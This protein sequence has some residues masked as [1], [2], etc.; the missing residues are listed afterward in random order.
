VGAGLSGLLGL[1]LTVIALGSNWP[2]MQGNALL[3]VILPTDGLLLRSARA[4]LRG[5]LAPNRIRALYLDYRLCAALALAA[6]TPC[7]DALDAPLGQRA[8]AVALAFVTWATLRGPRS[9]P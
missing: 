3:F 6:L 9:T 1:L 4:A 5:A 8:L 7:V 2:D